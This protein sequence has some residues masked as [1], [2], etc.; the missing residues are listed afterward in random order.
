VQQAERGV[1]GSKEEV[2][3]A[4]RE[5]RETFLYR[6]AMK[7]REEPY[8]PEDASVW[9]P[10][11]FVGED[12]ATVTHARKTLV[13]AKKF[14]LGLR[15]ARH[16]WVALDPNLPECGVE[17]AISPILTPPP[18]HLWKSPIGEI[19][20]IIP[21]GADIP[22]NLSKEIREFRASDD[23]HRLSRDRPAP[24]STHLQ[25]LWYGPDR[26]RVA[27]SLFKSIR[28]VGKDL[29]RY[30]EAWQGEY[31]GTDVPRLWQEIT[32][33]HQV[34]SADTDKITLNLTV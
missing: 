22:A 13:L 7:A 31:G 29:D 30:R 24:A 28:A 8:E 27:E 26:P 9:I 17:V 3:A 32:T 6:E 19:K 34:M 1:L 4:G 23:T 25:W 12:E 5:I 15:D 14:H 21:P 18:V 33:F 10:P 11:W 2:E 20:M 16:L